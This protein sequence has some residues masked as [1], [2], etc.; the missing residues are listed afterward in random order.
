MDEIAGVILV[1]GLLPSDIML[2]HSGYGIFVHT[3]HF[4]IC[5]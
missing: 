5:M 2:H 3:A 4:P 1:S